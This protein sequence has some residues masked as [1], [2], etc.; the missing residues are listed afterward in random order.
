MV[1]DLEEAVPAHVRDLDG[2][3]GG[4]ELAHLAG[5]PVEAGGLAELQAAGGQELH[6]DADAEER[7]APG[8]HRL[9][10]GLDHPAAR[11]QRRHAGGEGADAR[12]HHAVGRGDRRRVGGDQDLGLPL[13]DAG[14]R[15]LGRAQVARPVVDQGDGLHG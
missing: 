2:R 11:L 14:K 3:I 6:A 4:L 1:G 15:L 13:G 12:Q 10:H 5:D 9:G 7:P 8:L